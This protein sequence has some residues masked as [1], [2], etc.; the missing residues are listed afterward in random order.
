MLWIGICRRV[1]LSEHL[2]PEH[3]RVANL[4]PRSLP[5][6]QPRVPA[7]DLHRRLRVRVVRRL[8]AELGDADPQEEGLEQADQVG[9]H[10]LCHR[11]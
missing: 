1:R 7:E 9:L 3:A 10:G 6:V 8:E 2:G 5:V 11:A 4:G